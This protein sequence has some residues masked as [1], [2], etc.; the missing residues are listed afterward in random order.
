MLNISIKTTEHFESAQL[1]FQHGRYRDSV[2]RAYYAVYTAVED[3]VGLSPTG[4]WNHR[5]I[6]S[7]FAAR[8]IREGVDR[9]KSRELGR[10]F[11]DAFNARIGADYS[12]KPTVED[13]AKQILGYAQEIL[14]WI[15]Q[16]MNG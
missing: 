13:S 3:Y 10:K 15:Q 4:A 2:S 12:R 8:L 11:V 7:A 1:L 6:R 9:Q 14:D 16:E 5:S